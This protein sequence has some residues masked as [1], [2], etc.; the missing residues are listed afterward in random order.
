MARPIHANRHSILAKVEEVMPAKGRY[1]DLFVLEGHVDDSERPPEP[2]D[3]FDNNKHDAKNE[4]NRGHR[5]QGV[6][7]ANV[8]FATRHARCAQLRLQAFSV[9]PKHWATTAFVVIGLIVVKVQVALLVLRR[10]RVRPRPIHPDKHLVV[11]ETHRGRLIVKIHVHPH[12][13]VV[14]G[15]RFA[16]LNVLQ[17]KIHVAVAFLVELHFPGDPLELHLRKLLEHRRALRIFS[18]NHARL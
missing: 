1:D 6:V 8:N 11:D 13:D 2:V 15:H 14:H 7:Q 12:D 16:I 4:D 10:Q 17:N 3:Q 18:W 5:V 9:K